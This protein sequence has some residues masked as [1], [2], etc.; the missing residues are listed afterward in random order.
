MHEGACSWT[1]GRCNADGPTGMRCQATPEHKGRHQFQRPEQA[2]PYYWEN[3]NLW[4]AIP[5][6]LS[7]TKLFIVAHLHPTALLVQKLRISTQQESDGLW[8]LY[9]EDGSRLRCAGLTEAQLAL[10]VNDDPKPKRPGAF[11]PMEGILALAKAETQFYSDMEIRL[12]SEFHCVLAGRDL[13]RDWVLTTDI[14]EIITLP[15]EV[16][17]TAHA[18]DFET[19]IDV[20]VEVVR[21]EIAKFRVQGEARF[22]TSNDDFKARRALRRQRGQ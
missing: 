17:R 18:R 19:A 15:F 22:D 3:T 21:K 13:G 4:R 14:G 6:G 10:C 8:H 12:V 16:V 11:D 1:V 9:N 2:H 20:L 5:D 7:A